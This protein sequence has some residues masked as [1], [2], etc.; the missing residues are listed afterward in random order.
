MQIEKFT[1]QEIK[2]KL[3]TLM[4]SS[5][6]QNEPL[7]NVKRAMFAK[8]VEKAKT[9]VKKDLKTNKKAKKIWTAIL[10]R[11]DKMAKKK[12]KKDQMGFPIPKKDKTVTVGAMI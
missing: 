3:T 1:G 4:N 11:A 12:I 6:Y 9:D 2:K 8:E 10:E 7:I 5:K